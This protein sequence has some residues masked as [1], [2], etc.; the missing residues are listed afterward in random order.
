MKRNRKVQEVQ[1]VV[2]KTKDEVIKEVMENITYEIEVSIRWCKK[3]IDAFS[4]KFAANPLHA[5]EWSQSTFQTAGK[6]EATM[7]VDRYLKEGLKRKTE[8]A[9]VTISDVQILQEI[10]NFLYEEVTR[11]AK[12][13]DSSTSQPSNFASICLN[14]AKAEWLERMD[15]ALARIERA[16]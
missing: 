7:I 14:A 1:P 6:F 9:Y 8:D 10:R 11:K 16:S 4:A 15:N 13:P 2:K 3:E 5:L 12:W